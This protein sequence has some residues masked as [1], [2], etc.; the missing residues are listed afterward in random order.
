MDKLYQALNEG[1]TG[2]EPAP[3]AFE[4]MLDRVE[5]RSRRSRLAVLVVAVPLGIFA[6]VAVWGAFGLSSESG[7]YRDNGTEPTGQMVT[8]AGVE[9]TLPSDWSALVEPIPPV[10]EPTMLFAAGT[11]ALPTATGSDPHCSWLGQMPNDGA[12]VTLSEWAHPSQPETF[13][14][15][16]EQ[17]ALSADELEQHA[18]QPQ[19]PIDPDE[20]FIR[21]QTGGRYFLYTVAIG[22][23]APASLESQVLQAMSSLQVG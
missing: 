2:I 11:F 13:P 4:S 20:Y 21:F 6:I 7:A 14:V 22:P 23:D 1:A 5:R 8:V 18:C 9:A 15:L 10:S 19:L 12:L 16:S 17:F 3:T